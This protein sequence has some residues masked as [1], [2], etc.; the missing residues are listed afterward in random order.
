MKKQTFDLII[1]CGQS[2]K[3]EKGSNYLLDK[4]QSIL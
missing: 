1:I 2:N 4:E 3:S